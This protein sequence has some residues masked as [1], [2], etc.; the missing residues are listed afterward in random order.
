MKLNKKEVNGKEEPVYVAQNIGM[1]TNPKI[2]VS[3]LTFGRR[4]SCG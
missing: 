4:C 3:L 1:F 2:M